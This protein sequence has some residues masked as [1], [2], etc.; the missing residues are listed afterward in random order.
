MQKQN[1]KVGSTYIVKVSGALAKVTTKR[2]AVFGFDVPSECPGVP[3]E[4][5]AP[6]NT[7]TDKTAYDAAAK[8]LAGLF[9]DN[10]KVYEGGV[11]SE[12]RAAGPQ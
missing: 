2:D 5:L 4:I 6:R 1:V 11:S 12:V 3:K 10:F 9:R 8:K 7:W